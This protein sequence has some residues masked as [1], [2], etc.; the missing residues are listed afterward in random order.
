MSSERKAGKPVALYKIF[1]SSIDWSCTELAWFFFLWLP[2]IECHKGLVVLLE[3][4][5]EAQRGLGTATVLPC[6]AYTACEYVECWIWN[7]GKP[8]KGWESWI[9]QALSLVNPVTF[10]FCWE[11]LHRGQ[12]Q[13]MAKPCQSHHSGVWSPWSGLQR[14][15]RKL[16][17][18]R[19]LHVFIGKEIWLSFLLDILEM[20]AQGSTFD[21][22]A[23]HRRKSWRHSCWSCEKPCYQGNLLDLSTRVLRWILMSVKFHWIFV[24]G[25]DA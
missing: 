17:S 23:P 10:Q 4:E 19:T 22:Q 15:S 11:P 24:P 1:T 20:K 16:R 9:C 8:A 25:S 2:Q 13:M 21:I 3:E 18:L 6:L 5:G 14:L 12:G 7:L